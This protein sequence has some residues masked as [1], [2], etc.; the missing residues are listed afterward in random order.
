MCFNNYFTNRFLGSTQN[1]LHDEL[2]ADFAGI[3]CATK[4]YYAKWFLLGMGLG[5]NNAY[6]EPMP[7]RFPVYVNKLSEK[8]KYVMKTILI[9][10]AK[11]VQT[12]YNDTGWKNWCTNASGRT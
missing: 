6:E 7:G 1:N 2:V 10:V 3:V 12:W 8:A 4:N 5:E 9:K 11:N